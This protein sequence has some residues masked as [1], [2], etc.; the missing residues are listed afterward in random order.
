MKGGAM[1][2]THKLTL[3]EAVKFQINIMR[4]QMLLEDIFIDIA[5]NA[6]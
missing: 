4:S 1:I 5:M 6:D 2:Q 3:Q